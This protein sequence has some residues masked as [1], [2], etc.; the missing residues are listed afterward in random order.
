MTRSNMYTEAGGTD[1][2]K[3]YKLIKYKN[4]KEVAVSAH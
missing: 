2:E 4:Y 3:S 1:V